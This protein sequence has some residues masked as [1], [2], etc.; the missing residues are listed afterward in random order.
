ME[1]YASQVALPQVGVQGQEALAGAKV[2]VVG[3]GGLGAPV[4]TYLT[5]AGVGQLTVI[6]ADVV[7]M[8][9]LH[10]QVL[11]RT[12][13]VGRPKVQ[14][15]AEFVG[16]LNPDVTV[17]PVRDFVTAQN[18]QELLAGADVVVDCTDNPAS[19]YVVDD[20]ATLLGVPVVWGSMLR[21]GGQVTVF[22]KTVRYRDVFPVP[23]KEAPPCGEVGVLGPV[24]GV[25]GA[26]MAAEVVKL[27]V[28]CGRTLVG[29]MATVD[30]LTLTWN[31][32]QVRAD[33]GRPTVTMIDPMI[34]RACLGPVRQVTA[35]EVKKM[36]AQDAVCAFDVRD[37][38]EV[39]ADPFPGA[40]HVPLRELRDARLPSRP[41]VPV[42]TVCASGTRSNE[43][44]RILRSAGWND[45]SSLHGGMTAWRLGI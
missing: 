32:Y 12:S 35:T 40:V 29:R 41:G 6:D 19:R 28:G 23:V 10:R 44:A 13:D 36:L 24:C 9:N 38:E 2:T 27:V 22:D 16:A 43:A 11:F 25:V 15:A 18:A 4:V 42:V 5:G 17:V 3:T 21:F 30:A 26:T 31:E 7:E 14:V 1:R 33:P 45:V 34:D 39:C 8:A 20:A 37:P